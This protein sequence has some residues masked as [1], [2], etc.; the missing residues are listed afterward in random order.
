M[1][2]IYVLFLIVMLTCIGCQWQ[3]NSSDESEIEVLVERY[4]LIE[5][6]YLTTGDYSALQQMSTD[7]PQQ[8]RTLIE[9]V[10]KIG[11]VDDP[12][13]NVCQY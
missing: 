10:L 12:E 11:R 8:T 4:D 9:D 5:S 7:Y 1:R 6:L 13:I 3:L 2:K